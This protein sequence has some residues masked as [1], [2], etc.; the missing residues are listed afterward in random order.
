MPFVPLSLAPV[1]LC[2]LERRI[3]DEKQ[4][5]VLERNRAL[6]V[7]N[8]IMT[9]DFFHLL[10]TEHVLPDTMIKD[11]QVAD[12]LS[13]DHR[14]VSDLSTSKTPIKINKYFYPMTY[15]VSSAI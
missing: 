11:I 3:M 9:E 14:Y 5:E 4:R 12:L 7:N 10:K 13:P 1:F 15:L 2:S 8:M 6:L